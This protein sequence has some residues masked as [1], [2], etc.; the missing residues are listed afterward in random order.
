MIMLLWLAIPTVCAV[1]QCDILWLGVFPANS[2]GQKTGQ[3]TAF[4]S[5][6]GV[7]VVFGGDNPIT[8]P[9]TGSNDTWEFSNN[10]WTLRNPANRPSV[11][12]DAAM[13]F[14]SDRGVCVLF[15]G[16]S[17]VFQNEIPQNDTWEYDGINWV[18]RQGTNYSATDRP[19]PF[20]GVKMVYDSF[21]KRCV[22]VAPS[23]RLGGTVNVN[24]K[25]WE[26]DGAQWIAS[27][28][29]PPTRYDPAMAYDG[30]RHVTLL[31]GGQPDSGVPPT[32]D[33]WAWNGANWTQVAT[34]GPSARQEHAMTYDE[35]RQVVVLT[36][37]RYE[38][39]L[40]VDMFNDTW[41]WNGSSW[42]LVPGAANNGFNDRRLHHMWYDRTQ[43]KSISFGGMWSTRNPDGS[44]TNT[45]SDQVFEARPPGLWVDFLYTGA[46]QDG[47]F[48]APFK[49][50]AAGVSAVS[51]GCTL[52]LK[53]GT[54]SERLTISK[55][56]SLEVYTTPATIGAP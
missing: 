29:A 43:L 18:Q 45:I 12:K 41:Q 49:T 9:A 34:T 28:V 2:P 47:S 16:G 36:A 56:V 8:G 21:R 38:S 24:K 51:A 53:P 30:A 42:T 48:N 25:T 14:D 23:D 7:A 3:A 33:T 5:R 6:R 13:A 37:G 4:D 10:T 26:W 19:P 46:S 40:E 44:F 1:A 54:S 11:R 15:G 17:N 39:T 20:D 22:L 55:A 27:N 50:L 32:A 35:R 52:Y 31:H